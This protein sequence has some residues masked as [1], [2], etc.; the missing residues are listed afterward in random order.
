M[1]YCISCQHCGPLNVATSG[2]DITHCLRNGVVKPGISP[3][4]GKPFSEKTE[5]FCEIERTSNR[6]QACGHDAR[7]FCLKEQAA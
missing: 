1:I 7:F 5:L 4:T 2:S 6:E 3:V